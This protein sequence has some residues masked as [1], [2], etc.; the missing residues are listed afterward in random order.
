VLPH[1]V[2]LG[3]SHLYLS[4]L[5]QARPGSLHGYDVIDPQTVNSEL[6]GIDAL[7]RLSQAAAAWQIGLIADIVPNHMAADPRNPW[8]NDVLRHGR[9]SAHARVFDID[10]AAGGGRV[11]LPVL[12][13][14]YGDALAAGDIRI[15]RVAGDFVVQA[16]GLC[17]PIAHTDAPVI[18]SNADFDP[19]DPVGR[20][21]LHALLECQHYRL[22]CWR[23]AA[24]QLN[25]R[26]FFEISELIGVRVEDPQVFEA[27]HVLIIELYR[28]GLLQ[29]LRIDHVDGLAAPGKYLRALRTAL[30]AADPAREPYLIVEKILAPDE[31][32]DSRW[33][34]D[35]TTGY[36][37]M[38]DVGALLH[39]S[40]ARGPLLDFWQ[41]CGGDRR[42]PAE[43][44]QAL[45]KYFL[46]R[47]LAGERRAAIKAWAR[48]S[49]ADS[50][51]RDWGIDAWQ[52]VLDEWLA[53]FP[54][55]RS[56]AEDGGPSTAD[57]AF[58]DEAARLARPHLRGADPALLDLFMGWLKQARTGIEEPLRRLQQLSPPLAAKSLEDTLFYREASL[59]SRNEVGAWP[60]RFALSIAGFHERNIARARHHGGGMLAT[61]THD[62]KRGEDTRAR[63]AVLCEMPQ[64]WCDFARQWLA[65]LPGGLPT[66]TDR[67]LLLQTLMGA[68]PMDWS[69]DV[70]QIAPEALRAW[71]TR[72][73]AWQVKALREAKR[74]T[75]WTAPNSSYEAAAQAC[76]DVL[77][78]DTPDQSPLAVL[79]ALAAPLIAP[80]QI[81]GLAQT[82]L[83]NTSPGVPDLYQGTETWDLSLV[84][85]DNRRPVDHAAL[86]A[87]LDSPA[88]WRPD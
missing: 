78:P 18:R 76:L 24:E 27:T 45:R 47:H 74:H 38:D 7:R 5:T 13:Q 64:A 31:A 62:H 29:G 84:D 53:H 26:R 58:W 66:T 46:R 12:A 41:A 69:E 59:L 57:C 2:A 80:G 75:A 61:A 36:D 43:Q 16:G 34:V 60:Q 82:L 71:L 11:L 40:A 44:L 8:W 81:N 50:R 19:T 85:P 72:I 22:A 52:R 70:E 17:L 32:L 39:T 30:R 56:Y 23:T 54:V 49:A 88:P 3:I 48:L 55:Y 65:L 63:L 10:W 20:E 9:A 87:L 79:A 4:P 14:P 25:W 15:E 33:P 83:R 51:A 1:Y 68:W 35:G 77:S 37:F 67:Y 28:E 73:A 86:D 6:G 42:T 21:R